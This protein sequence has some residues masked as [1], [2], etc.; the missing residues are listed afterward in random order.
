MLHH[1]ILQDSFFWNL[2]E[3]T[4][5]MPMWRWK[6]KVCEDKIKRRVTRAVY[7]G[8]RELLTEERKRWLCREMGQEVGRER[9][10]GS[11]KART[12]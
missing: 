10:D 9:C 1:R 7:V 12:V 8:E 6:W 5:E 4:R 2:K 3:F 11:E